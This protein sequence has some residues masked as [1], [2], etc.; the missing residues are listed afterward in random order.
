M[1]EFLIRGSA[2]FILNRCKENHQYTNYNE[3]MFIIICIFALSNLMKSI[4]PVQNKTEKYVIRHL[5]KVLSLTEL[6]G[7]Q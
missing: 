3:L 7:I 2:I 5:C 1:A 4:C 6:N